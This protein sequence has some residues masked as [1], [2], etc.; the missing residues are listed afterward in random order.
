MYALGP[1]L[2][3]LVIDGGIFDTNVVRVP[4]GGVVDVTVRLNTGGFVIGPEA[5]E[6]VPIWRVDDG[7]VVGL[8][9][10]HCQLASQRSQQAVSNGFPPS[11]DLTCGNVS[12]TGPDASYSHVLPIEEGTHTLFTGMLSMSHFQNIGWQRAWIEIVDTI[13]PLYPSPPEM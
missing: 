8:S 7:P 5:T 2:S 3:T 9:W 11:F 4:A 13:G 1:R 10:E 6:F 12:Y